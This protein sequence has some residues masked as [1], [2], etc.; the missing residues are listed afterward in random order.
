MG[1]TVFGWF[2]RKEQFRALT[3]TWACSYLTYRCQSTNAGQPIVISGEE[4]TRLREAMQNG[5]YLLIDG[6]EVPVYFTDG[7]PLEQLG[8]GAAKVLRSDAF[9]LPISWN[10]MPLINLEYKDMGNEAA[11]I[12]ANMVYT[13]AMFLNDG[14]YLL[15]KNEK[16]GCL[17]FSL[18]SKMRMFLEA[19][20]L[21]AR[22]DDISFVYQAPTRSADPAV[23]FNGYANGGVTYR[24][25]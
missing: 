7:I 5:R 3:Q 14:M 6:V 9:L 22:I 18:S 19:P 8:G 24:S 16:E 11:K 25:A 15:T 4:T 21:A 10:G 1:G 12:L 2:L 23:T 20:F 17:E 13:S